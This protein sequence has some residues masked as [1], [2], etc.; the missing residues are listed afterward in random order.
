MD[1]GLLC[2]PARLGLCRDTLPPHGRCLGA[3]LRI[4]QITSLLLCHFP[5]TNKSRLGVCGWILFF[6]S[7]CYL[8]PRL[9]RPEAASRLH[10]SLCRSQRAKCPGQS[11]VCSFLT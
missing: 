4:T 1:L 11:T 9:Y 10:I 7:F 8:L 5:G 6:L 3:L 2:S